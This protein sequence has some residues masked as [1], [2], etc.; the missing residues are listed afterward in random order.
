MS[1][2]ED[3][4]ADSNGDQFEEAAT[5]KTDDRYKG[6]ELLLDIEELED[7]PELPPAKGNCLNHY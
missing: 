6:Y 5:K 7:E 3:E 1:R 2:T 4:D